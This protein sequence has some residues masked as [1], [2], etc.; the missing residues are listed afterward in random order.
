MPNE[1]ECSKLASVCDQPVYINLDWKLP[2]PGAHGGV[3]NGRS[4]G[5]HVHPRERAQCGPS[6]AI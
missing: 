5:G 4:F 3:C 2:L 1:L 6:T